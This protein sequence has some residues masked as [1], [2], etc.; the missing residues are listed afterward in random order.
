[1]ARAAFM[2]DRV[3]SKVG[4]HGKS[5]I[6]ML[7]SFACAIPGIMAT[8]TIESKKDRLVTILVAPLVSCSARLPIYVLMIGAFIPSKTFLGFLNLAGLTLVSMYLLG[9][10]AALGSAW[11]F[12][13]TLLKNETPTFI[14]ELP[15][16]KMPSLKSVLLQMW[17]RSMQFLNRA[18][19]IILGV[20]IILW[21]LATY[22]KL[23]HGTPSD[24][25][26]HSFAG[27]AGRIM[28]PVIKPLG[29]DWKIGLG[30]VG[31]LLQREVFVS[32]LG[33]IYGIKDA[34]ES[35]GNATLRERLQEDVDPVTGRR[36][37]TTLTAI[38]LMIYYV[39]A[40]QCMSTVAIVRRETNGW[41]WPAFQFAYMTGLAYVVTFIVYHVGLLMG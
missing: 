31:S 8:R 33:T 3:M 11:L 34:N 13:R 4:L 10:I 1:M 41:R 35:V 29:F 28:E 32:T 40:M 16:Y 30:L 5:F 38:C 25:L 19:T 27:Q 23:D 21:F 24:Q 22:P 12:K 17:N 20:S 37:F 18:G 39:L 9:L 15:P 14:M 2:M 6:P 26:Q 36:T 7:S